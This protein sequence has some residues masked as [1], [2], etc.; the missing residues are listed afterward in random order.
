LQ[1]SNQIQLANEY[2]A[3]WN[4]LIQV[5]DEIVL[6]FNDDKITFD[7][8]RE[9]LKTGLQFTNL[10]TI[11]QAI[12][13]IVMGDVERSRN[14]KIKIIFILGIN[15][16]AFPSINKEEGFLNDNDRENLKNNGIEIANGTLENLYEDQF[17]IYKA[18]STAEEKL[19]LSYLS[20][21]K[22]GKAKRQ[23]VIISKIKK[24]FTKI[25]EVSKNSKIDI[26]NDEATFGELL[27]NIRDKRNGQDVDEVWD[28]VYNW[29]INNAKW[30]L[31]VKKAIDGFNYKNISEI[32]TKENVNK[33]YGDT[34]KTSV[35]RLEQY[36]KCPFSF[37]LKYGLKLKQE[38][39]YTIKPVDT[40]T[41]MHDIIDTFF[42]EV[43]NVK[44]I[45]YLEIKQIVSD[46]IEEKLKL[47]KNYIF[48]SSSKFM[49]LTNRLK[50]VVAQSIKYITD[51]IKNSDFEIEG[52]EVEFTR[53]IDNI[54]IN[55]KI[56][57]IDS[58]QTENGKYIRIIDYKS[59]H[60]DINLNEFMSGVQI[61]LITYI[62]SI[63][64]SKNTIPAGMLYFNLD[65]PVIP[66]LKEGLDISD[67][68]IEEKIRKEFKMNGMILADIN[69]I[70][71]MDKKLDKGYSD[72]IPVFINKDGDINSKSS[73][74]ITKDDFTKLQNT[75]KR[76]IKGIA[77]QILSG[78][79]D[80]NPVYNKRTKI[81]NC[82]FC[83]YKSICKFNPKINKYTYVE[84]KKKEQ[85]LEELKGE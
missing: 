74:I 80:I 66:I 35:S 36:K 25:Q 22:D 7:K 39:E 9:A 48:S 52:N 61:Q 46:I 40:G 29:Y 51:Q 83:E 84:N 19:Y 58:T 75:A 47:N 54:T 41:F 32:L 37:Y 24:I 67:E 20:S 76:I 30:K 85:I 56:D 63:T 26:T 77:G 64:D 43:K 13:Q 31:K 82:Q 8:Y 21:D 70:R 5:L 62:D 33:L 45:E 57:R 71:K 81:D 59:S 6:V 69:I 23:S 1:K 2:I 38:E 73:N 3:S 12:D 68:Q 72:V 15:D 17:N 50:R 79:I 14:N 60:K 78:N 42:K 28:E 16:G 27:S 10:G 65:D 55:G 34:L 44:E 4:L 11:P 53:N 18:F 49:V